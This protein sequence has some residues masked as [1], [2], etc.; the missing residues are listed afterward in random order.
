MGQQGNLPSSRECD[1]E[2]TKPDWLK[3]NEIHRRFRKCINCQHKGEV[4]GQT[5]YMG[6]GIGR[7]PMYRCRKHPTIQFYDGT[8][9]CED[10]E[11]GMNSV[12]K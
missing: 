11:Q 6:K 10:Y 2:V 7:K 8:Y 12:T 1:E 9:A 4:C 3:N 5:N